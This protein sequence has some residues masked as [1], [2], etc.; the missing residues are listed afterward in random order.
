MRS[1]DAALDAARDGSPFSNGFE[2]DHWAAN[3][4]DRPCLHDGPFQRGETDLGCPLLMVALMGKTPSEWLEQDR[5]RLGDQY[6]CV[7]FRDEDDPGGHEP[8]PIPDPPG[9]E[10]SLPRDPY[11]GVRMYSPLTAERPVPAVT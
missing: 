11:E 2:Y 5:G 10:T 4:C 8:V 3:W 1:F 7:E 9:Q 6:H